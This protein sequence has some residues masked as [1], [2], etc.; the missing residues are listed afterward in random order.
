MVLIMREMVYRLEMEHLR[1]SMKI[2]RKERVKM[3]LK[4][5]MLDLEI[6]VDLLR[7]YPKS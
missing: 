7:N 5:K 3:I 4:F 6:K 2:R 1:D